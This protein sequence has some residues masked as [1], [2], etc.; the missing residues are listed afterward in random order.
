M[1]RNISRELMKEELANEVVFPDLSPK[2]SNPYKIWIM[3]FHTASKI[4]LVKNARNRFSIRI[5]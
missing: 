4:N 1:K 5:I 2:S 3:G